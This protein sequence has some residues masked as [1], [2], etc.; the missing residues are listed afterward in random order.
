MNVVL[1]QGVLSSEPRRRELPSGSLL[2]SWEVTTESSDKKQSVPVVWFDPPRSA[3]GL[4]NGEEVV[5]LGTVRRRF[6][7]AQGRTVSSTEVVAERAAPTRRPSAVS[8]LLTAAAER[9]AGC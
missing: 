4:A 6:Y 5:V 9:L 8:K 1:L 3:Q 7:A 2:L